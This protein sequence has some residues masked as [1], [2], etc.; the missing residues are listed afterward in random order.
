MAHRL[1]PIGK[2]MTGLLSILKFLSEIRHIFG[3]V[4]VPIAG[5]LRLQHG[6]KKLTGWLGNPESPSSVLSSFFQSLS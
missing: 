2:F 3:D 6:K 5:P 1:A 4:D